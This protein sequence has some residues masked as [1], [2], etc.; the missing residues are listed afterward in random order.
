MPLGLSD[1]ISREELDNGRVEGTVKGGSVK[2]CGVGANLGGLF[3][4]RICARR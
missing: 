1:Q 4:Q 2:S 3:D